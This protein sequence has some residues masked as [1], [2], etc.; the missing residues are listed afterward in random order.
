MPNAYF[1]GFVRRVAESLQLD[2][3]LLYAMSARIWQAVAGPITIV[4]LI[5][6]LSLEEQGVYYGLA[7]VVGIQTFF[8]LGLLNILVS[9]SAH[10]VGGLHSEIGRQ[11]MHQLIRSA[12]HWFLLVSGLFSVSAVALGWCVL[13]ANATSLSWGLPLVALSLAAAAGVAVSPEPAIL[14]GAGFRHSVYRSRLLQM[15]SGAVVVWGALWLGWK[16]WALV[17]SSLVQCLWTLWLTRILHR[18]FFHRCTFGNR[19]RVNEYCCSGII[20]QGKA[21][22]KENRHGDQ[23][24]ASWI[25]EVLPI[26]WRVALVSL[27]FHAATQFFTLIALYFHGQADAGRLGMTLTITAAIQG[28][29]LTWIHTK[30]AVISNYHANGNREAAGTLWRRAATVSSGLLLVAMTTLVILIGCIPLLGKGW[31]SRFIEPWQIAVLGVGC[32]SN[33]WIAIQSFYVLAQKGR[34]FLVP[35]LIGFSL[36]GLAV[37]CGGW[38][39]S[40]TGI[41]LG[42][43]LATCLVTLPGHSVAYWRYRHSK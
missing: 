38:L 36:T 19:A 26:Q 18:D 4:L 22:S 1:G 20:L 28:M 14:E 17:L 11:R 31:E 10:L 7:S 39:Y 34:P 24:G 29:S 40:I 32:L 15:I 35:S 13:S 43:T 2:R 16:L 33:H 6:C 5:H 30:F 25:R 8:E 12:R 23:S 3:T 37:F 41:V 42:Y 9:Q 27:V 21:L